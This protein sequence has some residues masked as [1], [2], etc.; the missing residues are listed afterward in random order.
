MAYNYPESSEV[1]KL[2]TIRMEFESPEFWDPNALREE[3][4]RQIE[5]CH[6]CRLCLPLCPDFPRLFDHIDDETDGDTSKLTEQHLADFTD[7]CYQCKL[8]F[9]KCPYTPPHEFMID[10]P[11]LLLRAKAVRAKQQGGATT[12]D[13]FLGNTDGNGRLFG[14][15]A[16]LANA[17]ASF[18]P[19]RMLMEQAV[20]IHRD[21]ILPKY[22]SQTFKAWY[23]KR[24]NPHLSSPSAEGEEQRRVALFYTCPVN[25]NDPEVGQ[26]VVKVLEHNGVEVSL[27]Q[28]R[29]CGQ[30][31][32]DG[33][34][35]DK[36]LEKIRYNIAGI[37]RSVEQG[38][39]V[40][41]PEP[42]CG[43]MLKKEYPSFFPAEMEALTLH[44]F[45]VSEYLMRLHGEGKLRTDFANKPAKLAYHMPCHLKYQAIGQQTLQL[46]RLVA[47]EVV[48]VDK[49]CSG[50]DG[51]WGMKK[52][53]FE[54]SLKVARGLC[55]G[56]KEAQ[57]ATCVTDCGMSAL[58]ILQGTGLQALH[59]YQILA[60]AYGL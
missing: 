40:L 45:E 47:D 17:G 20:G 28:E 37:R 53:Y 41:V 55:Q 52:E 51:T 13:K 31:Q 33:G 14:A 30:P 21:R 3:M 22:H 25:Y 27:V 24:G 59:P 50:M 48:F 32:L 5:V 11:K 15:V 12:Q 44:I 8:C 1:G 35:M 36:A 9:L 60:E 4:I 49:G 16:P 43:M 19:G 56:M 39:E 46:L 26:A 34:E 54:A 7:W 57:P 29:C 2:G 18:K 38:C 23:E 58:Q 42:T 6:G 10:I